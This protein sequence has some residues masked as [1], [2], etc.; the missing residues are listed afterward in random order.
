MGRRETADITIPVPAALDRW[1]S[2]LCLC[3]YH[4]GAVIITEQLWKT[5]A[6]GVWTCCSGCLTSRK[7]LSF[8]VSYI[9]F[10][11][12][13]SDLYSKVLFVVV[14]QLILTYSHSQGF[15]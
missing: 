13:A 15:K 12:N 6:C 10:F 4:G 5:L 7:C 11:L 2:P 3:I 9:F 1:L 14:F 8:D